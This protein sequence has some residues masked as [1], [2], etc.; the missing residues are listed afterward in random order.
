MCGMSELV[1]LHGTTAANPSIHP[2]IQEESRSQTPKPPQLLGGGAAPTMTPS[3]MAE[4]FILSLRKCIKYQL[5]NPVILYNHKKSA[6][7]YQDQ[8][9]ISQL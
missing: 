5:R 4:L 2:S 7:L 3:Q 6:I 8:C 9:I 1:F